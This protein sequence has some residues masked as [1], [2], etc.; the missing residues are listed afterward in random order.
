MEDSFEF[1]IAG[2]VQGCV[3]SPRLSCSIPEWALSEWRARCNGVGFGIPDGKVSLLDVRFADGILTS[4]KSHEERGQALDMLVDNL[5]HFGLVLNAAET[6]ISTRQNQHP[7]KLLSPGGISGEIFAENQANK[8]SSCM[9]S[10]PTQGGNG[11]DPEHE[12]QAASSAFYANRH[13]ESAWQLGLVCPMARHLAR[14]ERT[15]IGMYRTSWHQTVLP[16]MPAT[17]LEISKLHCQP[18]RQPL[19]ET[20]PTGQKQKLEEQETNGTRKYKLTADGNAWVS[21]AQ[22]QC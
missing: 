10:T 17:T 18:S 2:G 13:Y 19:V 4:T 14:L 3:L 11:L 21:G 15:R 12:P 8:C 6:K 20:C 5:R 9:I 16:E 7:A 1:D 22:Q